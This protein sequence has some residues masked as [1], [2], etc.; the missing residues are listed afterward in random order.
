MVSHILL[1][2]RK[3]NSRR[4]AREEPCT[5]AKLCT[6]RE[7]EEESEKKG[8]RTSFSGCVFPPSPPPLG[9]FLTPFSSSTTSLV[10]DLGQ[11]RG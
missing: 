9:G 8:E 11:S 1:K 10:F 2:E 5:S 4:R 6:E 7:G 3:K